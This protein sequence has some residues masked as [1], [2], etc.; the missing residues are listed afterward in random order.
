MRQNKVDYSVIASALILG[1]SVAIIIDD[2]S[3]TFNEYLLLPGLTTKEHIP[4]NVRLRTP[5]EKFKL[6]EGP[7]RHLNIPFVSAAMQSVS[8]SDLAIALAR[9]GG[10]AFIFCSQTIEA[11]AEMVRAVKEQ[12]RLCRI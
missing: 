7:K 12:S 11:Q 4:A 2:V 1:A 8:G 9:E 6:S 5:V 3:R 10:C